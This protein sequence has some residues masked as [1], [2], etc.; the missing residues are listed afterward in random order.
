MKSPGLKICENV[1]AMEKSMYGLTS[2]QVRRLAYDMVEAMGIKNPF[3]SSTKL[4]GNDWLMEF[5]KRH[6]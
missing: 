3:N 5:P 6:P 1:Q 2:T 4:A